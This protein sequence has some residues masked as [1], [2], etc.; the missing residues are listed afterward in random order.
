MAG[1][2]SNNVHVNKPLTNISIAY[3]QKAENFIATKVFPNI[4][5]TNRSD[6]Y[7]RYD[8]GEFNRDEM[9]QRA[10]GTESK[11]GGYNIDTAPAYFCRV[12]SFHK[13]IPDQVRDNADVQINVDRDA[14]VFVTQKALIKREKLFANTYF[15]PG[16][17]TQGKVGVAAN[18]T[19]SQVLKWTDANSDPIALVRQIKADMAED[20]GYEPNKITI[21]RRVWDALKDHPDLIDR[22]KFAGGNSNSNPANITREAI[23]ALFEI[24]EILVMNAIENI[25]PEGKPPVHKFIG[26]NHCLFNYV[27]PEP[28]LMTP[29]AGYTFSWTG[30]SGSGPMGNRIKQFRIEALE[31]DR[32]EISMAFDM[33][34]VGQDLGY[35]LQ[36]MA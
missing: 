30:Q 17:W 2:T 18:P 11:G 24:D 15:K 29:T 12:Y 14:T 23:A 20:T 13:D 36:D 31:S 5:S 4:P 35:F 8:R 21:G 27:T 28:G 25:A 7:Y 22:V 16:V 33:Q 6:I 3:M 1:P 19:G 34:I 32:V 9:E 10:P 26:G